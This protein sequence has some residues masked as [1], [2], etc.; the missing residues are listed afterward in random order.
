MNYSRKSRIEATTKKLA[1]FVAGVVFIGACGSEGAGPTV[2]SSSISPSTESTALQSSAPA[3]SSS[4]PAASSTRARFRMVEQKDGDGS[5]SPGVRTE[6]VV[7]FTSGNIQYKRFLSNDKSFGEAIEIGKVTFSK[8]G[9]DFWS[10][11]ENLLDPLS[12]TQVSVRNAITDPS[13]SLTYLRTISSDVSQGATEQVDGIKTTRY[14]ALA[15]LRKAGGEE[16]TNFPNGRW[17]EGANFPVEVWV[18]DTGKVRRLKFARSAEITQTWEF[19][20]WGVA[21]EISAPPSD[22]VRD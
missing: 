8:L 7:D 19:Y 18:D 13:R 10:R 4:A 14:S 16:G 17:P 9:G 20:E 5:R 11:Q 12:A 2:M 3:A 21:T 22:Q 15:D 1:L 6:G